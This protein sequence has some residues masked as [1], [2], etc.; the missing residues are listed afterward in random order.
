MRGSSWLEWVVGLGCSGEWA[1][2]GD[3]GRLEWE[4]TILIRGRCHGLVMMVCVRLQV[5]S[6]FAFCA[7]YEWYLWGWLDEDNWAWERLAW[8]LKAHV[9]VIKYVFHHAWPPP[10]R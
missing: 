3:Q 5:W 6:W 8:R 1:L 2:L 4:L 10:H 7:A 9:D